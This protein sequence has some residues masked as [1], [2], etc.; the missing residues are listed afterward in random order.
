MKRV[1]IALL[2]IAAG[3]ASHDRQSYKLNSRLITL[4]AEPQGARVYHIA[5]PMGTRVDLGMT[6]LVNQSVMVMT[7]AKLSST[8]PN[9]MA[10]LA[11][12]MNTA[13]LRVEKDGYQPYDVNVT[14]D[15]SKVTERTI[16][17]EPVKVE[18]AKTG[19]VKQ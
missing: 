11:A 7:A 6:P 8:D 5:A 12:Q 17:L 4:N 1:I 9:R 15:P 16:K 13:R 14:T 3:C 2:L 18:S 10:S 19:P